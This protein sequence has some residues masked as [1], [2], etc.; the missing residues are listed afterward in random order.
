M[1]DDNIYL[2]TRNRVDT[3][4]STTLIINHSINQGLLNIIKRTMNFQLH[5]ISLLVVC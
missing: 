1:Q 4:D 3:L 2:Q 5:T